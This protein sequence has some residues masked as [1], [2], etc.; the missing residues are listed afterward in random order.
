VFLVLPY[1]GAMVLFEAYAYVL[2]GKL[3]TF[4]AHRSVRV[5]GFGLCVALF[6][7]WF[8]RFFGAFG[9]PVPTS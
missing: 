9:G 6:L 3:G 2:H 4:F 1:L 5:L 7:V 8:A